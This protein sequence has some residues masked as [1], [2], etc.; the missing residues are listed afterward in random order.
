MSS[1]LVDIPPTN[2]REE[3]RYEI[4]ERADRQFNRAQRVRTVLMTLVFVGAGLRAALAAFI[5]GWN[6]SESHAAI[7]GGICLL[8]SPVAN[9]N[10]LTTR[11]SRDGTQQA[12]ADY[13]ARTR[14]S[15][16]DQIG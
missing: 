3:L 1:A 2:A 5:D 11:Q 9:A 15:F 4:A 16:T 7:F 12:Y 13:V 14:P 10:F 6:P 8:I